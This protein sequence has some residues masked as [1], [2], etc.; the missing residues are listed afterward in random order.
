MFKNRWLF[1]LSFLIFAVFFIGMLIFQHGGIIQYEPLIRIPIYIDQRPFLL[2]VFD[3]NKNELF[4]WYQARELSYV[5]DILDAYFIK[6][7]AFFHL[8]HYYSL[9]YFICL[10]VILGLTLRISQ[11]NFKYKSYPAM[12]LLMIVFLSSPIF[13]LNIN[14]VRSAKILTGFFLLLS[15]FFILENKKFLLIPFLL[16]TL[17][18]R[19]GFYYTFVFAIDFFIIY[20]YLKDKRFLRYFI[21]AITAV[22]INTFYNLLL[23][24]FLIKTVAGYWPSFFYQIMNKIQPSDVNL[25]VDPLFFTFDSFSYF[26]GNNRLLA[27]LCFGLLIY[28]FIK[29]E[30]NEKIKSLKIFLTFLA[31][32]EIFFLNTILIFRHPFIVWPEVRISYYT[33]PILILLLVF[34]LYVV[35]QIIHFYPKI[36]IL[37]IP[38]LLIIIFLNLCS[39][40][41][42]YQLARYT[43]ESDP[44][45]QWS[46]VILNCIKSNL[47]VKSFYLPPNEENFCRKIRP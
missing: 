47:P 46:E 12:M 35:N 3:V 15:I 42:Y 34:S 45:R 39:L 27:F 2:K 40:P 14:V 8:P 29:L 28:F 20:L 21:I 38:T 31:I 26:F 22:I 41:K 11:K 1:F 19:Q 23:A 9:T 18:D 37:L 25:I 6:W 32:L 30:S 10:I 24:P 4:G 36:E 13:F 33:I 43:Y 17:V 44:T 5:F 7:S 16:L